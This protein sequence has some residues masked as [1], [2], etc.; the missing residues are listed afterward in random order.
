MVGWR[1]GPSAGVRGVVTSVECEMQRGRRRVLLVLWLKTVPAAIRRTSSPADIGLLQV[2]AC[3]HHVP[4]S[5]LL[6]LR[7]V[8]CDHPLCSVNT[9]QRWL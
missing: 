2:E 7:T 8:T 4:A 3:C 9:G 6:L 5:L 1:R